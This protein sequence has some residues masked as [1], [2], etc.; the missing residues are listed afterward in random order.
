LT[1]SERNLAIQAED[2]S[3]LPDRNTKGNRMISK[4][5]KINNNNNNN[6]RNRI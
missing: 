5:P 6:K 2:L 1:G 4:L 3:L